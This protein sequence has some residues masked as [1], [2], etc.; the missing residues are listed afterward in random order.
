VKY[1]DKTRSEIVFDLCEQVNNTRNGD[2]G[3]SEIVF[4]LYLNE[5]LRH[6]TEQ[7]RNKLEPILRL[8]FHIFY[9]EGSSAIGCTSAV[10][11]KIDT[12]D[13]QPIRKTPYRTPHALKPVV[14]EHIKDIVAVEEDHRGETAPEESDV[15]S[16]TIGRKG[17]TVYC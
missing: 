4:D 6:L 14:E 11:H 3:R 17:T 5:K 10:K 1:G 12:G 9:Q 2:K 8:Y 16:I 15:T 13:A 7:D